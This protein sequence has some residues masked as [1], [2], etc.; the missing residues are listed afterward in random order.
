LDKL[1][2]TITA[3]LKGSKSL[4]DFLDIYYAFLLN[5][6]AVTY[7]TKASSDFKKFLNDQVVPDLLKN[8]K[9]DDFTLTGSSD[10]T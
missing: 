6:N 7:G 3:V 8:L 10:K 2:V 1:D 9:E 4:T 5:K